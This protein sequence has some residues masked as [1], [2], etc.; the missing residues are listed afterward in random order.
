[1]IHLQQQ[2]ATVADVVAGLCLGLARNLKANL[3][4]GTDLI[5]PIAF[6]GGVA[7]NRG[8]VHALE[9]VL[10]LSCGELFVPIAMPARA[11]WCGPGDAAS[12]GRRGGGR[13]GATVADLICPRCPA[14]GAGA[15]ARVDLGSDLWLLPIAM[16]TAG[17]PGA[18]N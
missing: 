11:R 3:A 6:C 17:C 7:A 4:R 15:T 18:S 2:G 12:T 16:R 8:V 13:R 14:A 10:G 1:M 5:R 9:T